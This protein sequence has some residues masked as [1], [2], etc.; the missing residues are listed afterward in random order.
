MCRMPHSR[1]VNAMALL[2]HQWTTVNTALH[3]LAQDLRPDE[4]TFRVAPGQNLL[5]FTLWHIPACQD[6]TVQT[7]VRNLPEVRDRDP[8]RDWASLERLGMAFGIRLDEA[9]AVARAVTG[10]DVLAYADAVLAEN[11]EWL[12]SVTEADLGRVPDNRAHLSRRSAY[13]TAE[14]EAEVRSM[15]NQPLGEVVTL[16]AGHGRAH[17]G[18]A[19]LVKELARRHPGDG[20]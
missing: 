14:Y 5:G 17:L 1:D 16:D 7:W 9:D 8:W 6:W 15:W 4:W 20:A 11:L 19:A 13:R 2:A 3:S 18:E 12:R 10:A